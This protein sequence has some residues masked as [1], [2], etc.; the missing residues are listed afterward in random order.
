MTVP[1]WEANTGNGA[2]VYVKPADVLNTPLVVWVLQH[3]ANAGPTE[4][5][6]Q[7]GDGIELDIV[8]LDQ[9]NPA[10]SKVFRNQ[11]W[12]TGRII[13]ALKG[14]VGKG[15][16]LVMVYDEQPGNQTTRRIH[17]LGKDERAK[18][19]ATAWYATLGDAGFEP[20]TPTDPAVYLRAFQQPQQ[21]FG[22]QPGYGPQG[23]SQYGGWPQGA[24]PAQQYRQ[25]PP[26]QGY[27]QPGYGPGQPPAQ[28]Q[29]QQGGPVPPAQPQWGGPQSAAPRPPAPPAQPQWGG[30]PQA[31][32]PQWGPPQQQ[33]PQQPQWGAPAPQPPVQPQW[34]GPQQIAPQQPQW[35][36]PQQVSGPPQPHEQGWEAMQA[37]QPTVLD[38]IAGGATPDG[39][40]QQYQQSDQPPF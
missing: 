9:S 34:G 5:Q 26:Q 11:T 10:E 37:A 1:N 12:R 36:A 22:G 28:P 2:G 21:R 3:V 33:A 39:P 19:I 23:G 29:W 4:R 30:Q 24:M 7:G 27:P 35:G 13:G 25:Q 8:Q 6:P 16:C 17:F 38:M 40:P 15:P 18:A 14:S 20:S 32:A 31:A